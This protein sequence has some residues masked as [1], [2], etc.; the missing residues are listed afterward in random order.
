MIQ[1]RQIAYVL[2]FLAIS[3]A[4]AYAE[5][6]ARSNYTR[7]EVQKM[8]RDAHTAEQYRELAEYYRSR[9]QSYEISARQEKHEWVRRAYDDSAA[10]KYP[11]PEDASRYRYE[12]FSYK[13]AQMGV[14][15]ARYTVL[16]T[17]LMH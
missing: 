5:A 4:A 2:V 10:E 9:Q 1:K 12:Y 14:L 13:A 7:A 15:A 11:T 6:P 17:E 3:C 16:A 8:I